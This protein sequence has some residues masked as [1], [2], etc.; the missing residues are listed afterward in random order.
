MFK[1]QR[2]ERFTILVTFSLSY[3]TSKLELYIREKKSMRWSPHEL[4][5]L[6][7][8]DAALVL[9]LLFNLKQ[10]KNHEN[11]YL[12]MDSNIFHK[13]SK[14]RMLKSLFLRGNIVI[15]K[16]GITISPWM[17]MTMKIVEF[18]ST[19]IKIYQILFCK[20]RKFLSYLFNL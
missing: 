20:E 12:Y 8:E 7:L 5:K 9:F 2:C 1:I 18:P 16:T 15:R 13:Q 19:K 3:Y 4:S 14:A 11:V 10:N 17:V 6:N